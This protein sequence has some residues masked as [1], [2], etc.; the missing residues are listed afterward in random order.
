MLEFLNLL[1]LI[2]VILGVMMLL[3][4]INVYLEDHMSSGMARLLTVLATAVIILSLI[5]L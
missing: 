5:H 2:A 4:R 3:K 1:I